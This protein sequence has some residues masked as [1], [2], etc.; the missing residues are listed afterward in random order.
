MGATSNNIQRGKPNT[1]IPAAS[2]YKEAEIG[3]AT[4]RYN[5]IWVPIET[6]PYSKSALSVHN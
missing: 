3:K 1:K 6:N 2:K 5:S 4:P